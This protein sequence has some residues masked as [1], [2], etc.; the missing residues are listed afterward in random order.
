M[1]SSRGAEIRAKAT[2][3]SADARRDKVKDRKEAQ[4]AAKLSLTEAFRLAAG[5]RQ[6]ELVNATLD[7]AILD[8]D[9]AVLRLVWERLEGKVADHLVTEAGD[10]FTMTEAQLAKWL[11]TPVTEQ[12]TA[13]EPQ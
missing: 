9:S 2:Q 7:R 5:K 12:G 10:P 3:A 8:K 1:H 6:T 13:S 11:D 4:E